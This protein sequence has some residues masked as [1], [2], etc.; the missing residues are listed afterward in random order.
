MRTTGDP[1][2][3]LPPWHTDTAAPSLEATVDTSTRTNNLI[4]QRALSYGP[5]ARL[6]PHTTSPCT[7]SYSAH[8]VLRRKKCIDIANPRYA[9]CYPMGAGI[10]RSHLVKPI[11]R[12]HST[13]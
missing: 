6:D 11:V 3:R 13:G 2:G 4:I 12:T 10:D 1:Y 7:H 9:M 8:S 5:L